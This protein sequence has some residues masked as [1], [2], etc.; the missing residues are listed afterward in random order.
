[1]SGENIITPPQKGDPVTADWAGELTRAVNAAQTAQTNG[2]SLATPFGFSPEPSG[3]PQG[4]DLPE[5]P[6]P[7]DVIGLPQYT[8]L[9][10][11]NVYMAIPNYARGIVPVTFGGVGI[12]RWTQQPH[13]DANSAWT[14]IDTIAATGTGTARAARLGFIDETPQGGDR[15]PAWRVFV[16][17]EADSSSPSWAMAGYPIVTLARWNFPS[18]QNQSFAPSCYDGVTQFVRGAVHLHS[19]LYWTRGGTSTTNY[20]VSFKLGSD[21]GGWVT[22]STIAPT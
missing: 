9:L 21:S 18:I 19:G 5:N 4:G 22:V 1:M 15:S 20:G 11:V 3:L 14:L 17:N 16:A 7:F 12:S 10:S 8:N 13:G 6:M 2:G